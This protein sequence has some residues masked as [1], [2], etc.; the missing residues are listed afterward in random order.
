MLIRGDKRGDREVAQT[1]RNKFRKVLAPLLQQLMRHSSIQTTMKF[2]A[3]IEA[4]S[5]I[6]EVRRHLKKYTQEVT[7]ETGRADSHGV[8]EK[9]RV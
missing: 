1:F 3:E 5:T 6:E 4:K 8:G 9:L 2:C 7:G